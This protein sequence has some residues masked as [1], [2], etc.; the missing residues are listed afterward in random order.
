MNRRFFAEFLTLLSRRVC[1]DPEVEEQEEEEEDMC[2]P[3]PREKQYSMD[4]NSIEGKMALKPGNLSKFGKKNLSSI[5]LH[6][7]VFDLTF[8]K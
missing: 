4:L 5:T 1:P 3:L 8:D 6:S 7:K 2:P